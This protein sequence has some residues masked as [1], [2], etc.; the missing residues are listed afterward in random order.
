[1]TESE[2]LGLC[3]LA[4]K[5]NQQRAL[6]KGQHAALRALID[7]L[8]YPVWLKD[9][10][11]RMVVINKA[12]QKKFGITAKEYEGKTD[13]DVWDKETAE[14]FR[15]N[16]LEALDKFSHLET[17][18]VVPTTKGPE[19]LYIIKTALEIDG[20][21]Y[22]KGEAIKVDDMRLIVRICDG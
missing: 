7:S 10:D 3:E 14:Q 21:R 11:S 13:F 2:T 15:K 18:E 1:M 19:E 12:Y 8:K 4:Q 5:A 9:E 6:E 20:K 16:D 22:I 17:F